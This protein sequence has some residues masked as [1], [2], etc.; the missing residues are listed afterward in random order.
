MDKAFYESM[1]SSGTR[2]ITI[3]KNNTSP[4]ERVKMNEAEIGGLY[5]LSSGTRIKILDEYGYQIDK[6][7][8]LVEG[9]IVEN[10]TPKQLE[11]YWRLMKNRTLVHDTD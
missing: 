4:L 10:L 5:V 11:L 8:E 1:I 7:T 9:E 2:E 6:A 3:Y